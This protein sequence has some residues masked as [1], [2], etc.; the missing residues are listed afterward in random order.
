MTPISVLLCVLVA[1]SG[2]A[3]L[4]ATAAGQSHVEKWPA[5]E[6]SE[7]FAETFLVVMALSVPVVPVIA[8]SFWVIGLHIFTSILVVVAVIALFP[9]VLLSMLD[10]GT[11]MVPFSGEVAR[12]VTK[13]KEEWGGLYFTSALLGVALIFTYIA[14]D[15]SGVPAAIFVSTAATVL[16]GFIYFGMIGRL[17][18]AI[19]H[20]VG[21]D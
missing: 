21:R 15:A 4:E 6:P 10:H 7:W 13:C 8:L 19:G 11:P 16:A 2:M 18:Y 12:S 20:N 5:F 17:A 14:C 1:S 3:V 9:F